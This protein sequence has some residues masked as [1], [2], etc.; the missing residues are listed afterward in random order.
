MLVFRKNR[1]YIFYYLPVTVFDLLVVSTSAFM[2][3]AEGQ[4]FICFRIVPVFVLETLPSIFKFQT[5]S[6]KLVEHPVF[7]HFVDWDWKMNFV[8]CWWC[9]RILNFPEKFGFYRFYQKFDFWYFSSFIVVYMFLRL[10]KNPCNFV[11]F[12]FYLFLL[13]FGRNYFRKFFGL[14]LFSLLEWGSMSS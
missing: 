6:R 7:W 11:K 14:S 2:I 9:S 4:V 12:S 3:E 8:F 13:N 10:I 5:K 1:K